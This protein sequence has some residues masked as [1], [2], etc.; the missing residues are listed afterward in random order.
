[1]GNPN[2]GTLLTTWLTTIKFS[3]IHYNYHQTTIQLTA[4]NVFTVLRKHHVYLIN[5]PLLSN[6]EIN[7]YR[8]KKNN[9]T[10][11][12]TF[13]FFSLQSEEDYTQVKMDG[14][15]PQV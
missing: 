10:S 3:R 7:S 2:D 11:D 13:G 12:Y 14:D 4:V 6:T 1:M 9:Y 5:L 8:A 15:K